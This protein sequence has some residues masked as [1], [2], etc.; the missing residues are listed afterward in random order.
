M[1]IVICHRDHRCVWKTP[2]KAPRADL[3]VESREGGTT[4]ALL[5]EN[6]WIFLQDLADRIVLSVQLFLVLDGGEDESVVL[7]CE[8]VVLLPIAEEL[9][10]RHQIE[11]RLPE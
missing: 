5:C 9:D 6:V 7:D 8:D 2:A 11:V 1:V 4:H 10:V 3:S